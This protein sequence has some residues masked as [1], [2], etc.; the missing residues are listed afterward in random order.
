MKKSEY[1]VELQK[2]LE[3]MKVRP[4]TIKDRWKDLSK[5]EREIYIKVSSDYGKAQRQKLYDIINKED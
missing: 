2:L 1:S 3:D 4:S 5:E